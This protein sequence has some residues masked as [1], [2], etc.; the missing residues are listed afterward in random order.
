MEQL[1]DAVQS[2]WDSVS[3]KTLTALYRSLPDRLTAVLRNHG[4]IDYQEIRPTHSTRYPLVDFV[5]FL[6]DLVGWCAGEVPSGCF[7]YPGGCPGYL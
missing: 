7:R 5:N 3:P 6:V 4:A 1:W 2:A